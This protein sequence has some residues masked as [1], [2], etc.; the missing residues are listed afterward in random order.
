[1]ENISPATVIPRVKTVKNVSSLER[2]ERFWGWIMIAPLVIGLLVFYFIPFLQTFF[3]SFT[4]LNQFMNWTE[5]SLDNYRDLFTDDDFYTATLNTLFYV[6]VCVPVSLALSLLLAIGLN[7]PIRGKTLFRT[8]LFL[9]A[10]TMPAAVAMVW[11]WLF[12]GDFGLVNH[13]LGFIGISQVDWLSDPKVVHLSVSIIIIWSSLALKII[14][15]LAGLQNIPRQV[16]EAADIDGIGTLRR[17]FFITLPLMMPTLFFVSIMSFIEVIQIFDVI[18]L[19]FDRSMIE[20]DAMTVT[21]LFYKYAFYLQEK[22]YASAIAVMLFI[23]TL[24]ISLVQMFI[25]KK[26]K[27]T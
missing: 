24:V 1:M 18:F 27:V 15:L 11:Q 12:N 23:V 7:Q 14:I 9:P 4:D 10:I 26:I 13:M 6:V 25:G 8:L 22:G 5:V 21:F 3:Y 20:S 16:Y 19:M 17:F 2:A